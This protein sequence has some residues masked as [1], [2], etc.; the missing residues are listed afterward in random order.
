MRIFSRRTSYVEP[1]LRLLY[2]D[3]DHSQLWV[4][5]RRFR[6][7]FDIT[8]ASSGQEAL[9]LMEQPAAFDVVVSDYHMPGMDGMDVLDEAM[10]RQPDAIRILVSG[11]MDN[12]LATRAL[13]AGSA[14][15]VLDKTWQKDCLKR[16]VMEEL[17]RRLETGA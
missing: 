5:K 16:A 2:V 8:V 17:T 15:R 3:D 7:L 13:S 11:N 12:A 4:M 10:Q 9:K 1:N 14:T 6:G